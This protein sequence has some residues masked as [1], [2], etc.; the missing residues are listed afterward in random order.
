MPTEG[1]Y[2]PLD[3]PLEVARVRQVAAD[4][5][6]AELLGLALEQVAPPREHRHIRALGR[7]R[8]GNCEPHPGGRSADDRR[9]AA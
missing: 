6:R 3:E 4:S 2:R 5:Q 1:F 7:Q 9:A 8:A